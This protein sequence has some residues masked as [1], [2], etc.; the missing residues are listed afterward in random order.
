MIKIGVIGAGAMG[1]NHIRNLKEMK[2]DLVGTADC[3]EERVREI[4]KRYEING[5]TSYKDLIKEGIEVATIVVPTKQHKEVAEFT[6]SKG[7]DTFIE[8]P[9]SDT[10]PNGESI[11][12]IAKQEEVKLSIGHIERFNPAIQKLKEITQKGELGEVFTIAAKRVGPYNPRIRDVGII[13]DL[14]VHDIDVMSHILQDKVETVYATGG[15]KRHTFE[16]FATI[17]MKLKKGCIGTIET[18]WHTPHKLRTLAVVGE[19]GIAE[20]DYIKQSLIT[21]D[22]EWQKQA[23]IEKEEPLKRELEAF[24]EYIKKGGNPP[25]SGEDALEALKVAHYSIKSYKENK[26]IR[27]NND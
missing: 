22:H 8:K 18:N 25:T 6:I 26:V 19:K 12:K 16:D 17:Q 3:N 23:K 2:V 21:Y 1:E 24:L 11:L 15:N 4:S 14:G 20:V 10:I 27:C 7:L 5:F 13:V 9:I